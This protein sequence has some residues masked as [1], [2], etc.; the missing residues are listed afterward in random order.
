MREPMLEANQESILRNCMSVSV[1]V[2]PFTRRISASA[3][4]NRESCVSRGISKG[5]LRNGLCQ[6]STQACSGART[7]SPRFAS[8]DR[9]ALGECANLSV[10]GGEVTLA[11]MHN[12]DVGVSSAAQPGRIKGVS[13]EIPHGHSSSSKRY[14]EMRTGAVSVPTLPDDAAGRRKSGGPL[15]K[16]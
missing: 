10:L 15:G 1:S 9:F 13:A 6:L 3:A 16:G 12:T 14:Q 11:Q 4:S 5:S 2:T 7:T 8:A